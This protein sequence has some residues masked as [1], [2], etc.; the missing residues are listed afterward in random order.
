M[1]VGWDYTKLAKAYTKRPDYSKE[2]IS[3]MLQIS[4][5]KK[6]DQICDIGAGDGH[7]TLILAKKGFKIIAIEPNNAMRKIGIDKTRQFAN[8]KWSAE[9]GELTNQKAQSFTLVTFGSSFNVTNRQK[10]LK[11]SFRI[12]KKNGWFVCMWNHRDLKDP[13]QLQIEKIITSNL[14]SYSYGIRREDQ[15]VIIKQSGLFKNIKSIKGEVLHKQTIEDCIEAWRSH[16]TLYR[17][18][19]KKFFAIINEISKY[20]NNLEEK[21]IVVPYTTRVWMAQKKI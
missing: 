20:L 21:I 9:T 10:A 3:K 12:L 5:I 4:K 19:G 6:N 18:A 2:A 8:I 7:L 16:G 1:K 14:N 11:E 17:Q 13:H 15:T